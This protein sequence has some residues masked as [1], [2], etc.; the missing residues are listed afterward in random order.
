[1]QVD[2]KYVLE[3]F[4]GMSREELLEETALRADEYVPEVCR[5]L[6]DEARA[7]GITPEQI[8]ACRRGA[9]APAPEPEA[10]IDFP[11]LITSAMDRQDLREFVEAL[12]G[13]G[14]PAVVREVDTRA[15]HGSGCAIGRWGLFVPGPHASAAAR[16]I[17]GLVPAG[18]PGGAAGC[19]G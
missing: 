17:E 13:E 18:E 12:R 7:R 11:A 16:R 1:M 19:G 15:F 9:G 2:P 14:I 6:E 8:E 10:T 5:M 3:R 4:R